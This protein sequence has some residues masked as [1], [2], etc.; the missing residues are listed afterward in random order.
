[1]AHHINAPNKQAKTAHNPHL[2]ERPKRLLMERLAEINS[3]HTAEFLNL[4]NRGQ[5]PIFGLSR[6]FYYGLE[7]DGHITLLRVRRRGRINGRT[8][9]PV[10]AM[11]AYFAKLKEEQSGTHACPAGKK[12]EPDFDFSK[13]DLS[14]LAPVEKPFVADMEIGV[15]K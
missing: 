3:K 9:I 4:P 6:S 7:R 2:P 8:L 11:R 5:D 10:D 14:D 13:I 12:V 1:M 15:R